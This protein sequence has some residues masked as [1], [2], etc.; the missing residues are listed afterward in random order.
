MFMSLCSVSLP[1]GALVCDCGITWSYFLC[2][3][4]TITCAGPEGAGWKITK[5]IG[6]LINT[7]PDP[8]VKP[9]QH[10]ILGHHRPASETPSM[11]F[12]WRAGGPMIS[13]FWWYYD[14]LFPRHQIKKTSDKTFWIRAWNKLEL[15]YSFQND[16]QNRLA[17]RIQICIRAHSS[18]L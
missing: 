13:R 14:H 7:G 5:Y 17:T 8:P 4:Q 15:L 9:S 3:P 1:L 2:F 16:T 18:R 11:A 12:R 10:A 6:F